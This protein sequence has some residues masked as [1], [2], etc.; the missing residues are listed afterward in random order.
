[1]LGHMQPDRREIEHLPAGRRNGFGGVQPCSATAAGYRAVFDHHVR[2]VDLGQVPAWS[3]GLLACLA[4]TL[5]RKRGLLGQPV[6]GRRHRRVRRV[7]VDLFGQP[8]DPFARL[9]KFS[10]TL[11]DDRTQLRDLGQRRGQSCFQLCHPPFES[12]TT[13]PHQQQQSR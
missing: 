6:R 9:D 10:V 7:A 11:D 4:A 13:P 5:A 2:I 3:A 1:M 12:H 8:R